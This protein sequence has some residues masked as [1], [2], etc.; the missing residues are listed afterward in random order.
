MQASPTPNERRLA[1]TK[2][3]QGITRIGVEPSGLQRGP[4]EVLG[5]LRLIGIGRTADAI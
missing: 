2:Q 1:P 4:G 5:V 3:R